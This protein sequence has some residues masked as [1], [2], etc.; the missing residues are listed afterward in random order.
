VL[1]AAAWLHDL[2]VF[3]GHRPEE[4]AAL[5]AW[6]NVTYAMS[7]APD[8]LKDFGF[9]LEKIPAVVEV[10]RTHQP[11]YNP[12]SREGVL[13]READILEQLGAVG[14]LRTVC[15]IGRDTRY[16]TFSDALQTLRRNLEQLPAKLTLEAA[17]RLAKT[18]VGLLGEFIA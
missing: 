12:T 16:V 18:R 11:A 10:I 5:A 7:K 14:V 9:P 8:L 6:D 13:L 1:Y 4:V 15:K 17:K 3:V 2:G